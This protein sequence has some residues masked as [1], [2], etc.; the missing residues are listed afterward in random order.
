MQGPKTVQDPVSDQPLDGELDAYLL[1]HRVMMVMQDA[2][3]NAFNTLTARSEDGGAEEMLP[4]DREEHHSFLLAQVASSIED[5]VNGKSLGPEYGPEY[6]DAD[7]VPEG[8]AGW[9]ALPLRAPIG[10]DEEEI[11]ERDAEAKRLGQW[12]V[13][14]FTEAQYKLWILTEWINCHEQ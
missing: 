8:R 12:L 9:Y 14:H 2:V 13:D 1:K 7:D 4:S 5:H 11:V 3:N 6:V 10:K